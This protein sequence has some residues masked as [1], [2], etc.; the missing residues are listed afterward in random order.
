MK[1][2]IQWL[3]AMKV[4]MRKN[5]VA[6][7]LVGKIFKSINVHIVKILTLLKVTTF[8]AAYHPSTGFRLQTQKYLCIQ[9]PQS[10]IIAITL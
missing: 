8:V 10:E 5:G 2:P 4:T 1:V 3:L 6:I 7:Q 9:I